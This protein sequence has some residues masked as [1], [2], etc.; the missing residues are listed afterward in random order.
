MMITYH[1]F[2]KGFEPA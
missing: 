2:P 1:K